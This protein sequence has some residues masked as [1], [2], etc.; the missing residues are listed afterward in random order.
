MGVEWAAR[1][2]YRWQRAADNVSW[3]HHVPRAPWRASKSP[4]F[5]AVDDMCLRTQRA[6]RAEER[7]GAL[8]CCAFGVVWYMHVY[9]DMYVQVHMYL[10]ISRELTL[11][12]AQLATSRRPGHA[13]GWRLAAG[14]W[15]L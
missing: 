8:A 4:V 10:C 12:P 9:I 11:R 6:E 14:G 2:D 1:G 15:R 5:T 13:S 3:A 7:S